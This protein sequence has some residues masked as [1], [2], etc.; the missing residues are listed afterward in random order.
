MEKNRALTRQVQIADDLGNLMHDFYVL[1]DQG[2]VINLAISGHCVPMK[3]IPLNRDAVTTVLNC[4]SELNHGLKEAVDKM[5]KIFTL[6]EKMGFELKQSV[7]D[8]V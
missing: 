1:R 4:H 7:N 8:A 5:E 6:L 3:D 2:E